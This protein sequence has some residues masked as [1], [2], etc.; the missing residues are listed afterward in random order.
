MASLICKKK[1]E[2]KYR[3]I[4]IE[5]MGLTI[6]MIL[7]LILILSLGS[8]VLLLPFALSIVGLIL[9]IISKVSLF[10]RGIWFSFGPKLMT[11]GYARLYKLAYVL[12]GTGVFFLLMMAKHLP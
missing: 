11:R 1:E 9:L 3:L 6:I 10:R 5:T 7:L 12:I 8:V 4:D 2:S